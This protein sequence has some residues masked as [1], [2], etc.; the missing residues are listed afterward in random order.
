[1]VDMERT[2]LEESDSTELD[3]GITPDRST[4][5]WLVENLEGK[6]LFSSP[7]GLLFSVL[8]IICCSLL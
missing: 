6:W 5:M 2:E 4:S 7:S 8:L 3:N 1:M